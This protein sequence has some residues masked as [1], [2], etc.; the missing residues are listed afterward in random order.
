M[1]TVSP[2]LCA[3]CKVLRGMRRC[4]AT[5]VR[6]L[7]PCACATGEV[8]QP[9]RHADGGRGACTFHAR[10]DAQARAGRA[11]AGNSSH[12]DRGPAPGGRA[13]RRHHWLHRA[14]CQQRPGAD[15]GDARA[16]FR[17]D[18]QGRRVPWRPRDR[19]GRR[20]R[21]G[22]L[23][24]AGGSW[25]RC[26]ASA[27]CRARD[28]QRGRRGSGLPRRPAAP[29]H[30]HHQG[31]GGG[32]GDQRRRQG[33]V[34]GHR[35]LGQSGRPARCAGRG[36]RDAD[37]RRAVPRSRRQRRGAVG[38]QPDGQ[39]LRSAGGDL[40]G[41]RHSPGPRRTHAL[42]WP[43]GRTRATG[44]CAQRCARDRRRRDGAGAR[45][46]RY[47]QIQA[48]GRV[49]GARA[50]RDSTRPRVRCWISASARG[51]TPSRRC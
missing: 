48:G 23:R 42:R 9:M 25:Q 46:R 21:H 5:P 29:A 6:Q 13:V 14:V 15:P 49:P 20:C 41:A 12:D 31:R 1:P 36:G 3:G 4:A 28:A 35:R 2:S 39:G 34:L 26:A 10:G 47:R 18:G 27:A 24:R 30:R 43:A 16:F 33:Q 19:P 37:F 40:A 45:R 11:A 22:G 51:R 7:R 38:R 17:R 8:L 44:R 50:I 32:R